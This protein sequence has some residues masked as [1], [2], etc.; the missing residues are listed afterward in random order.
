MATTATTA[1]PERRGQIVA[2]RIVSGIVILFLGM[3]G[4]MKLVPLQPVTDAV[5]LAKRAEGAI[6]VARSGSTIRDELKRAARMIRTVGGTV[7]GVVVMNDGG[8]LFSL[9]LSV[10]ACSVVLLFLQRRRVPIIGAYL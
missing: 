3:D 1:A 5:V 10:A 6:L 4:L 7:L 8:L 9:A 2:G